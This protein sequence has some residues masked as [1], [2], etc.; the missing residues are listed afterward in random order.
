MGHYKSPPVSLTV[1]QLRGLG[2][3]GVRLAKPFQDSRRPDWFALHVAELE[4]DHDASG[5]TMSASVA[6]NGS[7]T[8]AT[9][10]SAASM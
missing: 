4:P 3:L 2:V 6:T 7:M 9:T 8:I 1:R 10:L 5:V